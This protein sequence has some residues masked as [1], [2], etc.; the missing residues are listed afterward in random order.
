MLI[1]RNKKPNYLLP[2]TQ[3]GA[4]QNKCKATMA[5]SDYNK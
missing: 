2:T 4:W 5:G 1:L 3:A